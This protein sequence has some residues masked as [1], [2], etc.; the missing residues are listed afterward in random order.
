MTSKTLINFL[1][2]IAIVPLAIFLT[3]TGD[4]NK[5]QTVILTSIGPE[6]IDRIRINRSDGVEITFEKR[7]NDWFM[8]A[9]L[10]VR[11]HKNRIG[12]MLQLTSMQSFTR[13]PAA[14]HDLQRFD[15]AAPSVSLKLNNHEF[16]FGGTN[17]LEGR[18][19]VLTGGTIHLITDGLFPQLQQGPVFFISPQL[20]PEG[21]LLQSI[22]LP[23]YE[24][25]FINNRWTDTGTSDITA[26]TLD[27]LITA[28]QTAMATRIEIFA[29][30]D[31]QGDVIIHTRT[32]EIMHF[33]IQQQNPILK[34]ARAD[35][36]ITYDIPAVTYEELFP[37]VSRD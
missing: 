19:Y 25:S 36:G 17:P 37:P 15:L 8:T 26:D 13:L 18:R 32:G 21:T 23:G 11:A 30:M 7:T 1:L 34:L 29:P 10:A 6:T 24:F 31:T 14:E 35:L 22:K 27:R 33:E 4:K 20:I 9:P 12:A 3:N 16:I 2:I 28:W 5:D